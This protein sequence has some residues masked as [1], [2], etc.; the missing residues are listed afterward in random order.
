MKNGSNFRQNWFGSNDEV[1]DGALYSQ[2]PYVVCSAVPDD[3][4]DDIDGGP[5]DRHL[6]FSQLYHSHQPT[7]IVAISAVCQLIY[8]FIFI[9]LQWLVHQM[10]KKI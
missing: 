3:G 1:F 6:A 10:V 5:G 2:D 9:Y 8:L 4:D 7:I